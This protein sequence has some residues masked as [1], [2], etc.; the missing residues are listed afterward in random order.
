[1]ALFTASAMRQTEYLLKLNKFIQLRPIKF[2]ATWVVVYLALLAA[3]VEAQTLAPA[4]ERFKACLACHGEAGR[5]MMPMT[6]SLAGQPSFYAI[7]QLFLF[8]EGRRSNPVMTAMAKGMSDDDMRAFSELI[9]KLPPVTPPTL[10]D[11]NALDA[12]RMRNGAALVQ[13]NLCASCHGAD[14]A[15]GKQVARIANQRED[16][17]LQT[18]T[19]FRSGKRLGYTSAMNESL[20]GISPESL[21]DVA[22]YLANLPK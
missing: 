2:A 18:L 8:R 20:A 11:S 1:M 22:Y 21:A 16:Y 9:E 7:T 13:K 4:S 12:T 5:S 14:F 3:N 10:V 19:E 6:P 17:L 15:G